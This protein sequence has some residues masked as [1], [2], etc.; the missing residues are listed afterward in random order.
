MHILWLYMNTII[1]KTP[2]S[3][4]ASYAGAFRCDFRAIA[5][6]PFVNRDSQDDG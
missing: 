6:V 4:A 5:S 3:L 2:T 1:G